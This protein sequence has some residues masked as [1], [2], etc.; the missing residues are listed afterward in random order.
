MPRILKL[1]LPPGTRISYISTLFALITASIVELIGLAAIYPFL[2]LI[3]NPTEFSQTEI[4]YA[5][6]YFLNINIVKWV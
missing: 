4:G 6:K 2:Q 5:A 3:S 1:L